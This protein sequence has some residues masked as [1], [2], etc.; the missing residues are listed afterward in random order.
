MSS[1]EPHASVKKCHHTGCTKEFTTAEAFHVQDK[2]FCSLRHMQKWKS[3]F[4]EAPLEEAKQ[5]EY[6]S[7]KIHWR[8]R[9][10]R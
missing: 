8:G 7:I 5:K 4:V 3:E 1:S 9:S 10:A 2:Q 6:N